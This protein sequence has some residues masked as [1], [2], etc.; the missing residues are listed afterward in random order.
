MNTCPECKSAKIV[1]DSEMG[2]ITCKDCGLVLSEDIVDLSK[3][4]RSFDS[5]QYAD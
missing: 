1:R 2:E 3:E 4:W 5:D